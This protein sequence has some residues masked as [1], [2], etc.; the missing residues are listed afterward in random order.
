MIKR[1]PYAVQ[2]RVALSP[3]LATT[4]R[5]GLMPVNWKRIFLH[6]SEVVPVKFVPPS[7]SSG[8]VVTFF[9]GADVVVV[10]VVVAISSALER[11]N[12]GHL[13]LVM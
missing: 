6:V 7:S 5:S 10:V 9:I 2:L 11:R 4:I 1:S 13:P 12:K 8:R 3:G